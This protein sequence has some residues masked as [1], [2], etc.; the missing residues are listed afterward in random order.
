MTS[1]NGGAEQRSAGSS[2]IRM[3]YRTI[4]GY[5]SAFR[6]A[7]KGRAILLIHGIGDQGGIKRSMLPA[8]ITRYRSCRVCSRPKP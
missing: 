6:M 4:H 3:R 8:V 2:T 7:G 1:P 5:R